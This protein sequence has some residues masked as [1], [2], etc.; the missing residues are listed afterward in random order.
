MEREIKVGRTGGLLSFLFLVI[1]VVFLIFFIFR[2]FTIIET[3]YVGVKSI[4][5]KYDMEELLPGFHIKVPL[6]EEIILFNVKVRAMSYCSPEKYPLKTKEGLI[7]QPLIKVLDKRGLPIDVELTV[8]YRPIAD[9]AAE[10]LANWGSEWEI[11]LLN[12]TIRS[13]VRDVI[14]KIPAEEIPTNRAKINSMIENGIR[15]KINK[16]LVIGGKPAVH[17][18]AVLL[19]NVILPPQVE[20]KILEVQEAKQEAERTKYLVEKALNEQRAEKIKAETLKIKKVT[21]AKAEA[22]AILEKAKAQAE[23]NKLL[24]QSISNQLIKWRELDVREKLYKSIKENPNITIFLG[25][26]PG[27]IHL[28]E[29][30]PQKRR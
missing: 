13:I 28:W 17:V 11:K 10:I 21:E 29:Q 8:Q 25:S 14:G 7:T 15:E 26:P 19:R 4:L 6:V 3:G 12:P 1:L 2:P 27:G 16:E 30:L 9:M 5:G 22:E 20:R 23:A 24:S 18:V